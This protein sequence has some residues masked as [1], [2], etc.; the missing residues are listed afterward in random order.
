MGIGGIIC[1]LYVATGFP[2]WRRVSIST[3]RRQVTQK[4]DACLKQ[5]GG[6]ELDYIKGSHTAFT[7]DLCSVIA[8]GR[9]NGSWRD[10]NLY[11]C[12]TP[13]VDR[14]CGLMGR[15][16]GERWCPGWDEVRAYT[17]QWQPGLPRGPNATMWSSFKFQRDFSSSQNP[18][19]LSVGGWDTSPYRGA[20]T[21]YLVLGVEHAGTDTKAFIKINI[22]V[23]TTSSPAVAVTGTVDTLAGKVQPGEVVEVDY[24]KLKPLEVIEKA[25][26]YHES[27]IWL[28]WMLQN[29]KE[30]DLGDC[31]ACAA[32]RPQLY[33]EPAPLY[34]EDPWGYQCMLALTHSASPV[35]CITLARVFPPIANDTRTGPFTPHKGEGGY[36]C[37]RFTSQKPVVNVGE[38]PLQWCNGTIQSR[39]I[40]GPWARSGLYYYCGGTRLLV[41]IPTGTQGVCAMVR[42][43]APLVLIGDRVKALQA[44]RSDALTQ[45]RH[46]HVIGRR[47]RDI[48]DLTVDSPTYID[49]IGVPRGVPKEFKLADQVAAGFEN[50]PI[51]SALFPVTP[52]KNVDRIN[53]VHYNVLRLSNLTRDAIEGLLEQLGPTSLMAVQN[54]IALDMLLAE[55]GG[56]CA[57]F[58]DMCCTFIPNNTA[59]DGSV[60]KALQGLRTLSRTMHEHSGIDNPLEEWMTSMFGQWKGLIMSV[61][62][63]L[64]TFGAIMVTCGCCC[65]PCIRGLAMRVISTAIE[66]APGPPPGMLMPLLEQHDP[67]E[68]ELGE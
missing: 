45:R 53:Y 9:Y 50:I 43:A 33:T 54:R 34:S 59:P 25:T 47:S 31:V 5:G 30:Q 6:I 44:K 51:L 46:R 61:L 58:G 64:S 41:R 39:S 26:G 65:I 63:S 56:V 23:P 28:D 62:L 40:I 16:P 29:A 11:V 32:A 14:M 38:I 68:L 48:F 17:G 24:T 57:M 21:T 22:R 4:E 2:G 1:V 37:F 20:D 67:G 36:T 13:D 12:H 60:A 35:N 15:L 7:F 19:T 3:A 55:K 10:Y 42:L 18:L 52:N 66:K 8:C 49:A 27:N